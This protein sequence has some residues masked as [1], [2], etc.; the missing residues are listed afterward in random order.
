MRLAFLAILLALG[1]CDPGLGPMSP[2]PDNAVEFVPPAEYQDWWART[3]VCSDGLRQPAGI[4]WFVVPEVSS[5]MTS[6][7]EVLAR[8]SRGTNGARIVVAGAYIGS[9]FVV[10]HEMLHA[11]L[12]R[13]DHP[14]EYFVDR[15][16]LTLGS[17]NG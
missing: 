16:A 10:R 4:V 14:A 5:F 13:G 2:L 7:G 11:L 6:D 8:W 15:C 12:D 9:E 1:A 3:E 17:W